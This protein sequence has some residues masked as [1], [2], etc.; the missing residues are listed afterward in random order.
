MKN[1]ITLL[2]IIIFLLSNAFI[3]NNS[4]IVK[5]GSYDGQDLA[6]AIIAN[7]SWL[8]DSSYTDS[9]SM[10]NRQSIVLSSKGTLSP[11]HGPTFVLF[12]SGIA[13][14]DIVS[15]YEV[16]P[17]DERGSW[18]SGG[19]FGHPRDK[20]TLTLTLKV[21]PFMHYLYYD[22]QFFSAEYPEYVGTQ[23]N[24]K[25]TVIVDSPNQGTS[26]YFF[27]VNSGYFVWDSNG[28]PGSGFDIFATSGY[29]S[30]VD[31]V[32]TTPRTPGADAGASDVIPIGGE[33]HPVSPNEEITVTISMEDAGDNLFDSGAFIDNLMFSGFAKTD[34]LAKK[35][36]WKN[37]ELITSPVE[38]GDTVKYKIIITNTGSADQNNNPGNEFEDFIPENTTYIPG[39]ASNCKKGSANVELA[40]TSNR[41]VATGMNE[42]KL[43]RLLVLHG[44]DMTHL[45]TNPCF[46]RPPTCFTTRLLPILHQPLVHTKSRR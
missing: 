24:D 33:F 21:P 15:T 8:L 41:Q 19:K 13:G 40:V 38:C 34:I 12:S 22:V 18:F 25:F 11:T 7:S 31:I 6:L 9:D 29:P 4:E 42:T 17:G 32:D 10:G 14:T 43:L 28:I 16:E 30:N 46:H 3:V 39:S 2:F 27:D 44:T 36:A 45:L 26:E 35:T 5:A 37:G 1:K 23:Y 20:A